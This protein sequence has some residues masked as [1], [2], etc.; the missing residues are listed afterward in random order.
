MYGF[1]TGLGPPKL[2]NS[3]NCP[4][5]FSEGHYPMDVEQLAQRLR[6]AH[7]ILGLV[8]V[9]VPE[10]LRSTFAPVA[11]I[12]SDLDL[13]GSTCKALRL[14]VADHDR[15]LLRIFCYFD[16]VAGWPV[17]DYPKERLAIAEFNA[18]PHMRKLSPFLR[19]H[20]RCA[21]A[22]Q[23][24]HVDGAVLFLRTPCHDLYGV[25]DNASRATPIDFEGLCQRPGGS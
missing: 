5:L 7:F 24:R 2:K 16:D 8:E 20:I 19:P 10:F 11:F 6:R 9:T 12:S 23:R 21:A 25:P 3:P 4:Y 22:V 18:S 13:Y 17:G 14:L 15:L 1:D